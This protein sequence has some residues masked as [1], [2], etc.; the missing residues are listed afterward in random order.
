MGISARRV[1]HVVFGVSQYEQ[2]LTVR[3][4]GIVRQAKLA[5]PV[6]LRHLFKL[7]TQA[8]GVENQGASVAAQQV[9]PVRAN[10]AEVVVILRVW[11]RNVARRAR[12]EDRADG[13]GSVRLCLG[14]G[15]RS[16]PYTRGR[17]AKL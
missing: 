8:L 17:H 12:V 5:A 16:Y 15:R 2:Q 3:P 9:T 6:T 7:R 13:V 14:T 4:V 11:R 1:I 10:L